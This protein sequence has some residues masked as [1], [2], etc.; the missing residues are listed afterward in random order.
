MQ[1]IHNFKS[2]ILN[3]MHPGAKPAKETIQICVD[4]LLDRGV[5]MQIINKIAKLLIDVHNGKTKKEPRFA[6]GSDEAVAL[7]A[8]ETCLDTLFDDG[9]LTKVSYEEFTKFFKNSLNERAIRPREEITKPK[10]MEIDLNGPDGNAFA[11]M[12]LAKQLYRKLH[13]DEVSGSRTAKRLA[14]GLG[15]DEELPSPEDLLIADMM[16]GNYEHL[17]SVFDREFGDYVDL[18]R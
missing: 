5:K 8:L 13:P 18:F 7:R 4:R 6:K 1:H 11:L 14:K 9:F 17:I 2:F 10:K 15:N 16:S 3:E 12:A